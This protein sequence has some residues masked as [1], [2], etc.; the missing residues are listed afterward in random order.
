[1][2]TIRRMRKR[3][4][5]RTRKHKG[6]VVFSK[7]LGNV[8]VESLDGENNLYIHSFPLPGHLLEKV[9][10][11]FRTCWAGN[12]HEEKLF[13]NVREMQKQFLASGVSA[14]VVFAMNQ[15]GDIISARIVVHVKTHVEVLGSCTSS[16]QR[17]RGLHKKTLQAMSNYYRSLG[18]TSIRNT[19]DMQIRDGVGP[20]ERHIIFTKSGMR[21]NPIISHD[22]EPERRTLVELADGRKGYVQNVSEDGMTLTIKFGASVF[23]VPLGDV[24]RC[25]DKKPM[26]GFEPAE[27]PFIIR[28]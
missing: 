19:A 11:L 4:L 21:L 12:S 17:G 5:R 8:H 6:G 9:S 20:R 14:D 25:L 23:D 28:L 13:Q 1:M 3:R 10:E 7:P 26:A 2:K 16:E 18:F 27:C 22:N 24:I 15:S